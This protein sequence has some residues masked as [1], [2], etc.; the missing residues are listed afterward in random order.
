MQTLKNLKFFIVDDDPFSRMLYRQHLLN[1]GY[2]NNLLFENGRDCIS[3]L[4][5]QPDLVILDYDMLPDNGIEVLRMIKKYNPNIPLLVISAV[6]DKRV[7]MDAIK[8][9]AIDY[10][11]KGERDLEMISKAINNIENNI[12]DPVDS[13]TFIADFATANV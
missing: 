11:I 9:G 1:L 6:N 13:E 7:A 5:M 2:K 3:K 12:C 10:V 4:D 8:Y